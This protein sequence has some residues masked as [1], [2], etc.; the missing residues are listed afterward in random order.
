MFNDIFTFNGTD[1]SYVIIAAVSFIVLFSVQ[2]V[3]CTRVRIKWVRLLPFVLVAVPLGMA[4]AMFVSYFL[5]GGI[6]SGLFIVVGLIFCA[7]ALWCAAAIG[8]AW[9]VSRRKKH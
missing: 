3:L 6:L 1:Y 4:I 5:D 8:L 9:L 2:Y 7:Y